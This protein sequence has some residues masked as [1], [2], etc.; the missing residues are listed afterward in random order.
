MKYIPN[1]FCHISNLFALRIRLAM[2]GLLIY[3]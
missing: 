3:V 2:K 1:S